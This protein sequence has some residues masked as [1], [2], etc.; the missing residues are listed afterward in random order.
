MTKQYIL[1][2][3]IFLFFISC[4]EK[5]VA[6]PTLSFS[7]SKIDLGAITSTSTSSLTL[8]Q[9]GEGTIS[10]TISSNKSWLKLSKS[11]GT[12]SATDVISISTL[13]NSNDLVEGENTAIVSITPTINGIVSPVVSVTVKGIYKTTT[14]SLNSTSIDFGTITA[15]KSVFLKMTKIG[16]ENLG[17]DVSSDQSW[18]LIDKYSGTIT[19]TDSI[20]ITVDTK[21]LTGG[22]QTGNITITPKVNGASGKQTIVPVK[23]NYDDTITGIIEKRTLSKNET[24]GGNIS[25]NGNVTV[26]KGFVLTIKPGTKIAVKNTIEGIDLI[27]NGKLIMNGDATNIIEMKS[28]NAKPDYDDWN[29]IQANGDIEM[30]YC[31]LRDAYSPISFALTGIG[32][33][34]TKAPSIHHCLFENAFQAIDFVTSKFET[35]FYNLTFRNLQFNSILISDVK[36]LTIKDSEFLSS[37]S[38]IAIYTAGLALSVTNSNFVPKQYD[39]YENVFVFDNVKYANNKVAM[40]DCFGVSYTD[41]FNKNGNVF[42]NTTPASTANLNVGCGFANKYKSARLRVVDALGETAANQQ[43]LEY[44]KQRHLKIQNK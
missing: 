38:D 7:N 33:N 21:T 22:N 6:P 34:Q 35:T 41:G 16:T 32:I 36:V 5:E 23:I 27:I 17:F 14:I 12:I 8:T 28:E 39:F 15:N 43:M 40:T 29:G 18:L 4:K 26:P 19:G 10:Y 37:K 1:L 9:N 42:T 30:S 13:I 2:S 25:L 11:T 24:W 3:Y 31:Y 44:K 20:K